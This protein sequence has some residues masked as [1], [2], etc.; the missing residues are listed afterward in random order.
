MVSAALHGV[1]DEIFTILDYCLLML[2]LVSFL[3]E[4]WQE[5]MLVLLYMLGER[6]FFVQVGCKL[7]LCTEN[8]TMV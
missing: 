2:L 8:Y 3:R 6:I 4:L 5:I 1:I 7:F